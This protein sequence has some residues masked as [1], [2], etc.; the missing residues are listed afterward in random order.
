[1]R[2]PGTRRQRKDAKRYT[3][4]GKSQTLKEW[5]EEL[6]ITQNA[7]RIRMRQKLPP[8]LVFSPDRRI[9][10]DYGSDMRKYFR[11]LEREAEIRKELKDDGRL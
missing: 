4:N 5:S 7:I 1:M 3:Y 10:E 11:K 2:V 6:G 9:G 8:D